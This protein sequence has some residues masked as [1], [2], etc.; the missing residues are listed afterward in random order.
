M[1]ADRKRVLLVGASRGLGLGLARVFS[2]EGWE[3]TAT[4][5]G[6]SAELS[7][8][9]GV[10]VETV[11]IVDPEQVG[12]LHGRLAGERFDLI[13][14]VAGV[15]DGAQE[16]AHSVSPD[17]AAR[18]FLTNAHAPLA[19]AERFHDLLARGGTMA[20]MTST[21]GSVG[22]NT[23]GGWEVYRASKAALNTLARCYALRHAGDGTT[24][25]LMHPGWVRTDMGGPNAT[26]DVETS[27]TGMVRVIMQRLGGGG[28]TFVDYKGDLVPW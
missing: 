22:G 13:F 10:R 23:S 6:R 25:L 16:P 26:L 15:A 3:V 24:V 19:F 14:I 5:R 11:D 12:A 21:L 2:A 8:I 1:A 20:F 27:T 9:D 18:V 7:A 28:C 17:T 4:A